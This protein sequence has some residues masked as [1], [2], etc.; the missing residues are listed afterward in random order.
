MSVKENPSTER[1]ALSSNNSETML[2]EVTYTATSAVL[3]GDFV[4]APERAAVRHRRDAHR[5]GEVLAQVG[6]RPESRHRR[7]PLDRLVSRL[8]QVL[9]ATYSLHQQPL[10]RR[11][12]ERALEPSHQ[13]AGADMCLPRQVLQRQRLTKAT[14]GPVE[15]RPETVTVAAR[16]RRI[17]ELRLPA[18]PE[19][20]HNEPASDCV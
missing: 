12:A 18:I 10:E 14:H 17:D 20:W 8:Q 13:G 5:P 4:G 9:R 1:Q 7:D 15:Q 2:P 16:H 6:G 3:H 11:R 19:R